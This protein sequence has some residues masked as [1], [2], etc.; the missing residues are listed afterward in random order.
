[1]FGWTGVKF[2][3]GPRPIDARPRY[4][5]DHWMIT[6]DPRIRRGSPFRL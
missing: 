5:I 2:R 6:V 4:R 1:M 3:A